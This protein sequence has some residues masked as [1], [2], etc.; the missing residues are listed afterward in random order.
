MPLPK[1]RQHKHRRTHIH[2]CALNGIRTRYHM[3]TASE[4]AKTIHA[5]DSSTTVTGLFFFYLNIGGWSPYWVH[6]ALRPLLAYCTCPGWMSGWR[7]WWNE[8]VLAGEIE[9][10]GENL[11]RRHFVH[12][13]C[14]LPDPCANPGCRGGKSATNRL[15]F[16][17]AY[18]SLQNYMPGLKDQRKLQGLLF[19]V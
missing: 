15:S 16:C 17:A 7:S 5:L 19:I 9:V 6:S 10:L 4:R 12:H 2:L 1:H 13:K 3:I 18:R 14:Q 8:M 11:P